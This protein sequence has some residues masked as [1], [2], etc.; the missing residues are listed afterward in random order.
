MAPEDE[1]VAFCQLAEHE[2]QIPTGSFTRWATARTAV[3][4]GHRGELLPLSSA[5]I[6][7][8]FSRRFFAGVV[9]R[10]SGCKYIGGNVLLNEPFFESL[11]L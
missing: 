5:T 9:H 6:G 7:Y 3:L 10:L 4:V 2:G 1:C 8:F 11:V